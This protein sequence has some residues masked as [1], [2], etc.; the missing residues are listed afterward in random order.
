MNEANLSYLLWIK[1]SSPDNERSIAKEVP[2][3]YED[4]IKKLWPGKFRIRYRG[5]RDGNHYD[6]KK[7][8]AR[9]FSVY[10]K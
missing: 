9:F 4:D 6:S 8:T 5:P 10:T 3:K 2:L 7:E 1:Y